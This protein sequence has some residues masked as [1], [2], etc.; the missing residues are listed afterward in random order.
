MRFEVETLDDALLALYPELL[1]REPTI[2]ATRG[3][4][5]EILGASIEIKKLERDLV[6]RRRAGRSLAPW[7]N[8][9]GI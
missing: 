4:F 8:C 1:S 6:D 3:A 9:F 7:V 2:S 5:S